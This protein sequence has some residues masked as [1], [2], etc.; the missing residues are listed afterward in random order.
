[1]V[2]YAYGLVIFVVQVE[3]GIYVCALGKVIYDE[4]QETVICVVA[5]EEIYV[6]S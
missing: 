4:D 3:M 5:P 6:F 1:M 2:I